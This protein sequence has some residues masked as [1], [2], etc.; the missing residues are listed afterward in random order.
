M[1]IWSHDS[2][3]IR[4]KGTQDKLGV[5]RA[6]DHKAR[7]HDGNWMNWVDLGVI[8]FLAISGLLAFGRGLVREVLGIGAW[9]GAVAVAMAGLPLMRQQVRTWFTTPEWV[10][11]VSFIVVFLVTLIVLSLIARMIGGVVRNSALGGVDRTLGLLFGLARGASVVIIAY[12]IG[13]MVLPV[14][15]WPDVVLESRALGPTYQAAAWVRE[16]L[17]EDYRPHRL[18]P[19]PQGRETTAEALLRVNPQGRAT[20]RPPVRE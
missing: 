20:G 13:Q 6:P 16:Q 1:P 11:P 14:E 5:Q 15:R 17:P 18:D 12:I 9:V 19:P 10:D 3:Q 8:G 4:R 7:K 2:R